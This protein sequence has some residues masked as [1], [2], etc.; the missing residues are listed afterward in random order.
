MSINSHVYLY[1]WTAKV[2]SQIHQVGGS[3]PW[4]GISLSTCT[5][6]GVLSGHSWNL[7]H[8]YRCN[9]RRLIQDLHLKDVRPYILF[10]DTNTFTFSQNR[11]SCIC[12]ILCRS[13]KS[14][15]AIW[16]KTGEGHHGSRLGKQNVGYMEPVRDKTLNWVRSIPFT[17][18]DSVFNIGDY[19]AADGSASMVI[20]GQMLATL[21][22]Q[23]GPEAQFQ[24]IYEDSEVNDFLNLLHTFWK[25]TT[26]M[27]SLLGQ[28]S[29]DNVYLQIQCISS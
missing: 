13:F 24:V 26:S 16:K 4:H 6:L 10:S 21:K 8:F 27:F 22:D 17:A 2:V 28:T 19:G 23:H 9:K 29:T 18:K 20:I 11:C 7:K 1:E 12:E 5:T 15:C 14:I 25:W 3:F